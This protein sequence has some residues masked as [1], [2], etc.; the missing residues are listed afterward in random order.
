MRTSR[1]G[2]ITSSIYR[3]SKRFADTDTAFSLMSDHGSLRHFNHER[4]PQ[5][6]KKRQP[7]NQA[8]V[9][10][11]KKHVLIKG[12]LFNPENVMRIRNELI[13]TSH[14]VNYTSNRTSIHRT[15]RNSI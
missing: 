2:N 4:H 12:I 11:N 10:S 13:H 1:V 3:N 5:N 14:Q 15:Y 8:K 9:Q 7:L 6:K